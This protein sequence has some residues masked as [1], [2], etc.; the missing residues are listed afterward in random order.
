MK[1]EDLKYG[2]PRFEDLVKDIFSNMVD[3]DSCPNC[4]GRLSRIK[5]NYEVERFFQD[6]FIDKN[7][8]IA[9]MLCKQC[10]K[11][12]YVSIKSRELYNKISSEITKMNIRSLREE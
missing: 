3:G 9:E 5:G 1:F 12:F 10:Y 2:G 4:K 6:D 7:N 8:H 11:K